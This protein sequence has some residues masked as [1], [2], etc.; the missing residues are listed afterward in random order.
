MLS[1]VVEVDSCSNEGQ[2]QLND[3]LIML[4][5]E[6]NFYNT[7]WTGCTRSCCG[8]EP[9]QPRSAVSE[10]QNKLETSLLLFKSF[11]RN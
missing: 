3:G 10:D 4:L 1:V 11:T 8:G 5:C 9:T 7:K 2:E 6:Y